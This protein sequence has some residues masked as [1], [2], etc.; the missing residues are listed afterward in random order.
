MASSRDFSFPSARLSA[1]SCGFGPDKTP[2]T[3]NPSCY[4]FHRATLVGMKTVARLFTQ[5]QPKQ[6]DVTFVL[7]EAA[8]RFS[9]T[10]K[11]Q[12]KKVGRPA[13]RI[14]LHQH[15][16]QVTSATVTKHDRK[17]DQTL[18]VKRINNHDS[19]QE[20]RL[21]TD[22]MVY[23]GEYTLEL[24]FEAP[25][26]DG[27]TGIY[28]CYFRDGDTDKQLL[29][30]QLESHYAREAFPCVDEP[31]AKAV[32]NLTLVTR[33]GITVLGNTPVVSQTEQDGKLTTTFE[34]TPKMST[35]LLAFV[36]GELHRKTTKTNRNTEVSVWA[37]VAQP[38]ESLDFALDAAKR[39]I[40]Y[41]EEYFDTPYP[42]AKCDHVAV[43]DFSSGAMENWGLITYRER[44]LLAYPGETAQSSLEYIAMV[45]AHETSHQWFGN[46]VTM[47]WWDDLW[48]NESFANMMEYQAV[49]NMFPEWHLWDMFI[50]GDGLNALRRDSLAGVQAV[51]VA[52]NHPDEISALFDPSIV[53]AK[54]GRLLYMLKNYIG[55]EAFRA[56][57]KRYFQI[58]AYGNTD[59]SDLWHALSET[60]GKDIGAFMNPWLTRS[61]FPLI[62]I[63]QE[64]REATLQQEH[65]V[66]DRTKADPDRIWT[67]P[68]FTATPNQPV[69]LHDQTT[70]LQLPDD[71]IMRLN[72][73]ARGHY[74]VRYTT[75]TQ[76]Q[77]IIDMVRNQ[78]VSEADRLILLFT[79]STLARAGYDPYG[80]VLAMLDAYATETSEPVWD[81]MALVAGE[82]R[83]FIDLDPALEDKIKPFTDKLTGA[84]VAR[85]GWD[86]I[87]GESSHDEKLRALVLSLSA[88]AEN[89]ATLAH[90]RELFAAHKDSGEALPA[91]LRSL[92]FTIPVKE[93]DAAAFDFLL[94]LH[95]STQNGDLK[96]DALGALTATRDPKRAEQLLARL[97]DPKLVKPQDVDH[98]LVFLLRNRY[99]RA[100][101]W[102]WLVA[103]WG[104]LEDTFKNDKSYDYLP[105]YAA[106]CVNTREYQ[107]KF[108]DLFDSKQDQLLLKRNI[109]LGFEEIETRVSWLERDL[110]SVQAFF[111]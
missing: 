70:Q 74:L 36:A 32:F 65:F 22:Q 6:Y 24:T 38:A 110:A 95:E 7:D 42:L 54:G 49:D 91:E 80:S 60:S 99:T 53:Y 14:T 11:I 20:V 96:N 107:Q 1:R 101:A 30:T 40:E 105:R 67:V 12:G 8:K 57:L 19:F 43:P 37:T 48:L 59:G 4:I 51:K 64:G 104:W 86:V 88:Y 52:V 31:E 75:D 92:I 97:K 72:T 61:G 25:I 87:P 79:G 33:T 34:P 73:E 9:G 94:Q 27:M 100:T 85:L 103:N 56:G 77:A 82:S 71:A 98:W 109:Q 15:D 90:A 68:L 2:Q 84:Q 63:T 62:S 76:K 44:V 23:P 17:G 46:L 41:F 83:R 66:E 21:H 26:T 78:S 58:H 102:D 111:K 35:Y 39:S 93:G 89:P 29:M 13:Q 3:N 45:V 18:A 106:S 69:D 55:E 28:P 16:L 81:I 47:R 50:A 10:V 5:F 108:H